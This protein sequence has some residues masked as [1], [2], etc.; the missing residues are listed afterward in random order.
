MAKGGKRAAWVTSGG[1]GIGE[2]GA[3][4]LA[5][6]GWTTVVGSG[7]RTV[8]DAVVGKFIRGAD[9]V[10]AIP[11]HVNVAEDV[12]KV[13][14]IVDSPGRFDLLVN[15]VGVNGRKRSWKHMETGGLGPVRRDQSRQRAQLR[16][17]RRCQLCASGRMARSPASRLRAVSP[18]LEKVRCGSAPRPF[19]FT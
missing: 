9:A 2:A 5:A 3:E 10:E 14:D 1:S 17:R 4:A 18:R 11:R 8:L 15:S 12:Q 6:D 13:T 19:K 7:R 16:A